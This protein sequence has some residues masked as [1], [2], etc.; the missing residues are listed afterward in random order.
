MINLQVSDSQSHLLMAV[1]GTESPSK[2]VQGGKGGTPGKHGKPGSGGPGGSG[3]RSCHWIDN[4]GA[5]HS[6]SGGRSGNRGRNGS[7]PTEPLYNGRNGLDGDF[8]IFVTSSSQGAL[9][10]YDRRYDLEWTAAALDSDEALSETSRIF[11]FG[12]TVL[13]T[14]IEQKNIGAMPTPPQPI[15]LRISSTPNILPNKEDKASISLRAE[16]G[17]LVQADGKLSFFVAI[18]NIRSMA[19][20]DM[21][22]YRVTDSMFLHATQL[23]PH[24]FARPYDRFDV[25][26]TGLEFR[27]P[28]E[29]GSGFAGCVGN[30]SLSVLFGMGLE[31]RSHFF[32]CLILYLYSAYLA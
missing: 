9:T 17:S 1:Q 8:N 12:D 25:K 30:N 26:G 18:P 31:H 19:K 11:Q 15:E 4:D 6:K 27:F 32:G 16:P 2:W 7:V 28:V 24:G 23:G 3:G 21:E 13:V 5:Y 29:N 20:N 10:F 22:P 14:G